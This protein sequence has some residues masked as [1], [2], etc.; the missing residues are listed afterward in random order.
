MKLSL[1]DFQVDYVA[2][3]RDQLD[4]VRS[5]A[6]KRPA[7]ALLNAPTGSGKT[8]MATALIDELLGGDENT[9]GDPRLTFLWLTDQPE[10]NK[11][12]YDK[13]LATS[14]VL[15]PGQLV[16]VDAALDAEYLG[17]GRVYFLNTQKLGANT[18]FVKSG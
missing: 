1:K 18:S 8:L 12:T 16:V 17:P 15:L 5:V 7:A 10:L 14:S 9:P 2:E 6:E 4:T 11:Q 3:L 13:M